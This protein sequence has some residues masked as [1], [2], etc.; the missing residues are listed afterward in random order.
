V[1]EVVTWEDWHFCALCTIGG[2]LLTPSYPA[3][4]LALTLAFTTKAYDSWA[5]LGVPSGACGRVDAGPDFPTDAGPA[6]PS[7]AP[8]SRKKAVFWG[9][10]PPIS[11]LG[12]FSPIARMGGCHV[13]LG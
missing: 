4:A 1:K 12:A 10:C 8:A 6:P 3:P 7:P 13:L 5:T 2:K 9:I 11:T